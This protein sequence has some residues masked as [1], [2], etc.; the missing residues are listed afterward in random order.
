MLD[1]LPKNQRN[2]TILSWII[3]LSAFFAGLYVI[4]SGAYPDSTQKWAFGIIGAIIGYV[5]G[6]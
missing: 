5:I 6:N 2:K 1:K 3:L 4:L